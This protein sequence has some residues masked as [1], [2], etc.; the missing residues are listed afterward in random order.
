MLLVGCFAAAGRAQVNPRGTAV[1]TLKGKTVSVEYGRPSLKGRSTAD[2]LGTLQS[3][4]MQ[5]LLLSC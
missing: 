5:R 4:K 1:L 3:L 2:L